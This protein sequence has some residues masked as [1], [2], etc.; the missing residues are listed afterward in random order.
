MG[1]VGST[2][3][4]RATALLDEV[5]RDPATVARAA[6]TMAED[7]HDPVAGAIAWRAAGIGLRMLGRITESLGAFDAAVA[8][9][10]Q[11]GDLRLA[12][13]ARTSRA[14]P[15][16]ISGDMDG[17]LADLDRALTELDG[18]DRGIALFQRAQY[19]DVVEDP[20]ATAAF[21]AAIELLT[22]SAGHAKYLGHALA[23][24][25]VHHSV[26]G[27]F[28]DARRDLT[29]ALAIWTELGLEALAATVVHNLGAVAMFRGEFVEALDHF[30]SA[31]HRSSTLGNE[32]A[33]SGRDYCDALLAVGL[34]SEA[35]DRAIELARACAASGD[36]LAA[37]ELQLLGAHAALQ[38]GDPA[39]TEAL[40]GAALEWFERAGR[41]GWAAQ[42][43]LALARTAIGR[44]TAE[45][46]DLDRLADD[47]AARGWH[48][49]A[50]HAGLLAAEVLAG[51]APAGDRDDLVA[52]R[53]RLDVLLPRLRSARAERRLQAVTVEAELAVAC[54]EPAVARRAVR[55]GLDVVEREQRSVGAV[56][57]RA[58]FARHA[59]DLLRIGRTVAIGRRDTRAAWRDLE[60]MR[61]LSLRRPRVRPVDDD[62]LGGLLAQLRQI[63]VELALDE[64][65]SPSWQALARAQ[66][67]L[68]RHI[69]DHVRRTPGAGDDAPEAGIDDVTEL[70]RSGDTGGTMV[71][72]D[73]VDGR[74]WTFVL[75][76]RVRRVDVG[77]AGDLTDRAAAAGLAVRRLARRTT[78]AH[79]VAVALEQLTDLVAWFD[80][81]LPLPRSSGP[82][83]LVVPS[84]LA[85]VPWGALP[86][87]RAR[88][89]TLAPSA[90]SWVQ[91]MRRPADATGRATFL[92]GPGLPMA[93]AE[94]REA[95]ATH[96]DATV[97][98][99]DRAVA[100]L[101]ADAIERSGLAHVAAHYAPRHGNALF[102]AF[103]LTDGPWFLHDLIRCT[104][105]PST[106]VVPSCESAV[107]EAPV[108]GE[109]LGLSS[110]LLGAGVRSV[111]MS[112]GLV[113]DDPVTVTTMTALHRGLESGA[114]AAA[115]LA[116]AL[117]AA[118]DTAPAVV[119]RSTVACHGAW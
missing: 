77:P 22:G 87:L 78:N 25:G 6:A 72:F 66:Q 41:P 99:G 38:V 2:D 31:Q 115:A 57:A 13:L 47:L 34:A 61:A 9:A 98:T 69:A 29:A 117:D 7:A 26:Y 96:P 55:R 94:V 68:Q 42:A 27:R 60:R 1:T 106:W 64:P 74:V 67:R 20:G 102:S 97:L 85:A 5:D 84:E 36:G 37:A 48:D 17:G 28:D 79:S 52:A 110:V 119:L 56:D 116:D 32:Q 18:A 93:A 100:R 107:G 111:V 82:L 88:P 10:E 80:E 105:M 95:A 112:S 4:Q 75:D 51:R 50:L 104:S 30:E 114:G 15:R 40:A 3:W 58:H 53:A 109:L 59:A 46:G 23:N 49:A 76:G 43:R 103:E 91:A 54:G 90:W 92:A 108:A 118:G 65:G 12:G 11:A 83:A 44:G 70:L 113:P 45:V 14:A 21:D 63:S 62:V 89:L 101:A 19:L 35:R 8:A 81:R 16:F 24:R 73:V 71:S 33:A 39:T 86:S